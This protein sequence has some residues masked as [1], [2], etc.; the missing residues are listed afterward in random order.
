[1]SIS[2]VIVI[3]IVD[4]QDGNFDSV[5]FWFYNKW[6]WWWKNHWYHLFSL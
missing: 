2:F 4:L 3:E 1:M 6:C 5:Y